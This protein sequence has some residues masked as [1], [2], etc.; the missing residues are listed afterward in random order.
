MCV[1]GRSSVGVLVSTSRAKL[2]NTLNVNAQGLKLLLDE[3]FRYA[4]AQVFKEQA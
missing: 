2:H 3:A 1:R 4:Y